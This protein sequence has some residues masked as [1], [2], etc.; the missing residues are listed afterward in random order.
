MYIKNLNCLKPNQ[1]IKLPGSYF[2]TRIS[3]SS[4]MRSC[5]TSSAWPSIV[6]SNV[7][8][9]SR[10]VKDGQMVA[11][12]EAKL[13][14]TN[15]KTVNYES[16]HNK[17]VGKKKTKTFF[18]LSKEFPHTSCSLGDAF[19]VLLKNSSDCHCSH[20][21]K[22][23]QTHV[24]N[25]TSGQNHIGTSCQNL[26]DPLLGDVWFPEANKKNVIV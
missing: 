15:A 10:L 17:I 12:C 14:S 23:L 22:V 25:A 9:P 4:Q 11:R 26:L 13:K 1:S 7:S 21:H 20:I 8:S 2:F 16:K 6:A 19:Q 3:S 24:V 5:T 18:T